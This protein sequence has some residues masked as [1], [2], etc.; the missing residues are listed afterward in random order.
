MSEII[1]TK[2]LLLTVHT[3]HH[4]HNFAFIQRKRERENFN[5]HLILVFLFVVLS[6]VI[7]ENQRQKFSSI[8]RRNSEIGGDARLQR[9]WESGIRKNI[10]WL[11][12][13]N[14][15]DCLQC[16]FDCTAFTFYDSIVTLY[17]HCEHFSSSSFSSSSSPSLPSFGF[18]TK[19]QLVQICTPNKLFRILI[20]TTHIAQHYTI[21]VANNNK[22]WWRRRRRRRRKTMQKTQAAALCVIGME[23]E[24]DK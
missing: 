10:Q 20:D 1:S 16:L 24:G 13:N 9:D 15:V 2:S 18:Y 23:R 7:L 4:A 17:F 14:R 22:R 11:C 8:Q 19:S 3:P 6:I 5:T 21:K 12:I